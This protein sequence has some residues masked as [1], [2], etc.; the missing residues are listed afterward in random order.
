VKSRIKDVGVYRPAH[1]WSF[2]GGLTLEPPEPRPELDIGEDKDPPL[3]RR[4]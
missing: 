4:D 3:R 2:A 1:A